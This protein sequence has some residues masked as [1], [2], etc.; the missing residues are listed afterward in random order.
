MYYRP[1][2]YGCTW[3]N[4]KPVASEMAVSTPPLIP[5]AAPVL[6]GPAVTSDD[7]F[8]IKSEKVLPLTAGN[9][10][11]PLP[12][13]LPCPVE[14]KPALPLETHVPLAESQVVLTTLRPADEVVRELLV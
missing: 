8:A 10:D 11:P 3:K 13:V 5:V 1:I 14:L 7:A 9:D 12:N 2:P 4:D 6:L